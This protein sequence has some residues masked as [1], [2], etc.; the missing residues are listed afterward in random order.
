MN[1][2]RVTELLRLA[3][4]LIA[5]MAEWWLM[6]PYHEPVLA[7]AWLWLMTFCYTTARWLGRAGLHA[8]H[9]YYIAVEA[10]L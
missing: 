9:E 6:Q 5:V 10:G 3:G 4:L 7:R 1:A 8:E 2:E